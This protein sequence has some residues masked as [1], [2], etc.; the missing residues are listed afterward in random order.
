MFASSYNLCFIKTYLDPWQWYT[1][2][3]WYSRLVS[4]LGRVFSSP[5]KG[6]SDY[7]LQLSSVVFPSLCFCSP[8]DSFCSGMYQIV[9][10]SRDYGWEI[11]FAFSAS[12][13]DS[14]LRIAPAEQLLNQLQTFY[15]LPL[16]WSNEGKDHTW[17]WNYLNTF[18]PP[19][20]RGFSVK[21]T[22]NPKRLI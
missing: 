20:I 19:K 4:M 16:Y 18:E 9:D 3:L 15:L 10:L 8:V 14:S 5:R 7:P 17:S 11:Y 6:F 13:W 22:I 12:W 1:Y 2:F 21:L